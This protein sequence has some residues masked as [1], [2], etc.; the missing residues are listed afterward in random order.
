MKQDP[1]ITEVRRARQELAAKLHYDID[2]IFDHY[3]E[4]EKTSGARYAHRCPKPL[5]RASVK[6]R[7]R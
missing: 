4:I 5:P 1:I 3:R 2:A 6:L 7:S